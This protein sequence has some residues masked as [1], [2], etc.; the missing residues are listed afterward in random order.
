MNTL[1]DQDGMVIQMGITMSVST[2]PPTK[3]LYQNRLNF[4]PLF[5]G[6]ARRLSDETADRRSR[7]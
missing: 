3:V 7:C 6:L 2:P 1:P 5:E 4:M